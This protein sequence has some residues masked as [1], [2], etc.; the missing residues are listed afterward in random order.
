VNKLNTLVSATLKEV[1]G[2]KIDPLEYE[3]A[4]FPV[5]EVIE[6]GNDSD[7]YTNKEN[8]RV[9]AFEVWIYQESENSGLDS[10]YSTLRSAVDAIIDAFDNDQTLGGAVD[11]VE[12]AP[13]GFSDFPRRGKKMAAAVVTLRCHKLKL[14]S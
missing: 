7:Y 2:Y 8:M 12:P 13:A 11:W 10:A 6:S 1:V 4:Q 9:Y 5:A 3:F 14:L